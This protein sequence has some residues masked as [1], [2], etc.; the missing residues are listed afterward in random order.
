MQ[1]LAE[2]LEVSEATGMVEKVVD[3]FDEFDV[4]EGKPIVFKLLILSKI[5]DKRRINVK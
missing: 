2:R 5:I 1:H 4:R 3:I